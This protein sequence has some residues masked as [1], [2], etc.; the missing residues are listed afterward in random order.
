MKKEE[1]K[2]LGEKF[3]INYVD[4][5]IVEISFCRSFPLTLK[6]LFE[7]DLYLELTSDVAN[8]Y[9]GSS[10]TIFEHENL[11]YDWQEFVVSKAIGKAKLERANT[12][13]KST[14]TDLQG[15]EF[16]EITEDGTEDYN[17]SIDVLEG[18]VHHI[19][20]LLTTKFDLIKEEIKDRNSARKIEQII[21]EDHN[22]YLRIIKTALD[23]FLA[24][25]VKKEINEQGMEV[26]S[27]T[28]EQNEIY[29]AF[30]ESIYDLDFS[31]R[32]KLYTLDNIEAK[33]C[34]ED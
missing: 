4:D 26:Y 21:S 31:L 17:K 29:E 32:Q 33:E 28:E 15:L 3:A 19:N 10:K 6:V 27:F 16:G 18:L 30:K 12:Y 23:D 25:N 14:L 5:R 8:L 7:N 22:Q 24:E 1:L 34:F 20:S 13:L 11:T 9:F 2:A